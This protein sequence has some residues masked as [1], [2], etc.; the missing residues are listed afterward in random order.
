MYIHIN[1]HVVLGNTLV[2]DNTL[3][4]EIEHANSKIYM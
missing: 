4:P 2:Q 1:V 3:V